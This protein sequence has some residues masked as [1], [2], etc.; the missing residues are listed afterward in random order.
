[1][2]QLLAADARYALPDTVRADMASF[3]AE[4]EAAD[5]F[6]PKQFNVDMTK[7]SPS[8]VSNTLMSYDSPVRIPG[9]E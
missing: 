2:L 5:D 4:L 8:S 9:L 7:T 3:V 6:D 1:L